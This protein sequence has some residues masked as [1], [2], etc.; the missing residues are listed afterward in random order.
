[1]ASP[2]SPPTHTAA[3]LGQGD[4]RAPFQVHVAHRPAAVR[5]TSPRGVREACL[6]GA[7]EWTPL[8][9]SGSSRATVSLTER[10]DADADGELHRRQPQRGPEHTLHRAAGIAA[11][12]PSGHNQSVTAP[13]S[14]EV[15]GASEGEKPAPGQS[16]SWLTTPAR[17]QGQPG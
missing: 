16:Q 10:P 1:M 6:D 2:P 14:D 4:Q 17:L 7:M 12:A 11:C 15:P 13:L 3:L 8:T 5:N 9:H